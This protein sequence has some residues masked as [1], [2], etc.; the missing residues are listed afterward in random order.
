MTE[1]PIPLDETAV[2]MIAE[3]DEQSRNLE[4][5]RITVLQYFLRRNGLEGNYELAQNRR[6]VVRRVNGKADSEPA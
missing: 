1:E 6:E 3:L 4:V 5:S 2:K